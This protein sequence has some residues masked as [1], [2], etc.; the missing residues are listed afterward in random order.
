[1]TIII[2]ISRGSIARN[3]LQNNFFILIKK[4]FDKVIILTTAVD[5]KRF[6]D[7]FSADNV[8]IIPFIQVKNSWFDDLLSKLNTYL[9]YN[10]NTKKLS[11][12]NSINP[13]NNFLPYLKYLIL[14][15][16]FQPLSKIKILRQITRGID[17]F[18]L[19]KKAVNQYRKLLRQRNVD[20]I[21]CTNMIESPDIEILKAARKEKIKNVSM[22]KSWDNPSKTYFRAKTDKSIVWS[23]FMADQMKKYQDYKKENIKIIGV[24]QFDYYLNKQ[25]LVSRKEFCQ[26]YSLDPAKKIILFGSEGKLAPTEPKVVDIISDLI[27]NKELV[28]S[29]Q[30]LIRPHFGYKK[31]YLKFNK[32]VKQSN[33]KLD[34]NNSP[35][36]G[37]RD[38]W[39]YSHKQMN[40]FLNTIYHSDVTINTCST[41]TLDAIALGKPVILNKFDGYK[42]LPFYQ[43]VARWYYSDYYSKLMKYG[44]TLE[45]NNADELKNSINI[46]LQKPNLLEKQQERLIQD[47]CYKI[48]GKS[49]ERL[50]KII[51]EYAK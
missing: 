23:K 27:D 16:I 32:L 33:V 6:N 10:Q 22:C 35:S 15:M 14:R 7:E 38:E 46:L 1:M 17:Y 36:K 9:I 43:S 29:C 37:F 31:D 28:D 13:K 20:I 19:Q 4:K 50:F 30:I 42:K 12:Y 34:L 11:L 25:L 44:A 5:E 39:D 21:F 47:F 49:G 8:E 41:L 3:I 18:F 24:P 51:Y 40:N 48:D 2:T 45:A 26:Q